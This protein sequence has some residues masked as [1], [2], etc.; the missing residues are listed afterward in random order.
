MNNESKI[1]EGLAHS[2]DRLDE[3]TVSKSPFRQFFHWMQDAMDNGIP[4]PET[5]FLA[6]VGKNGKPSGRVVLLKEFDERGFVFYTNYLSRKGREIGENPYV[7]AVLHWKELERQVRI[8]GKVNKISA[9]DSEIYFNSRNME[10]RINAVI[11]PQ[12]SVIPDRRFLEI[13]RM[14][15]IVS[16]A[17][18]GIKRPDSWGGYRIIP[19]EIEFWQG[20]EFRLH[21][22]IL[23]TKIKSKW[24]IRRLAP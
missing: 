21:D 16:N 14:E 7:A 9:T 2:E 3:K 4:E 11:S 18:E 17:S 8:T 10:S 1:P 12:S 13:K 19:S 20:Q 15:L 5:M 24:V 6:T 22:R 23:Y